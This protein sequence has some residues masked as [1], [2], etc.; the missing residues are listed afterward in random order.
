MPQPLPST[1]L[2]DKAIELATRTLKPHLLNHSVRGFLFG[3]AVAS[4]EGLRPDTDYDEETMFLICVL[5]DIGL[6]E[7]ANGDQPFEIDGADYAAQFLEDNGVTDTRVD[8]VWDAIASH[9][10]GF[11]DSPVYRRRRPAA[12]W[13]AVEGIGIDVGGGPSDL[14]SGYADQVHATYPRLGGT[15]ALTTSIETQAL[16]NPRKAWP[17]TLAGE[18][19]H[20]RHPELP[21]MTWDS[22]IEA[23]GWQ[24]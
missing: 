23:S 14:P 6:A 15:R 10:S 3:Q 19:V 11:T 7:I 5:H 13:I 24:D 21:Y 2:A 16:A 20:Q 22:I 8:T 9:T 1:P 18:I 12:S 17:A 4:R